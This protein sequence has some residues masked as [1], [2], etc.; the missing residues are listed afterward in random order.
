M[1][2]LRGR[3]ARCGLPMPLH[4]FV[5][6]QSVIWRLSGRQ[7]GDGRRVVLIKR[8]LEFY[9]KVGAPVAVEPLYRKDSRHATRDVL[10]RSALVEAFY[11]A[12]DV[13]PWVVMRKEIFGSGS[14]I[15]NSANNGFK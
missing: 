6:L 13:S 9:D 15:T 8:A 11:Q 12:Q 14:S 7:A 3:C 1:W 10:T 4:V 5:W 2:R